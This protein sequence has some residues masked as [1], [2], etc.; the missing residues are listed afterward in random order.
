VPFAAPCLSAS[1]SVPEA[2][3]ERS[4]MRKPIVDPTIKQAIHDQA[5]AIMAAFQ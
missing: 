5:S 4:W 2:E 1:I 3:S